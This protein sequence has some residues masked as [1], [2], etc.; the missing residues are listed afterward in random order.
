MTGNRWISQEGKGGARGLESKWVQPYSQ[1][2]VCPGFPA[3]CNSEDV[4]RGPKFT[5]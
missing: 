5:L 3:A 1:A 2:G 4:I